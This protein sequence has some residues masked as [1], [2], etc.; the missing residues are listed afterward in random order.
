M[1]P[2]V[3]LAA[4]ES[5]RMGRPKALLPTGAGSETFVERIV[6]T[7][8]SAGVDR[9]V[10]V[11]GQH[12]KEITAVLK[13]LSPLVRTVRNPRVEG[14]QLSSLL[15]GLEA[16]DR[17]DAGGMLVTLVDVPLVAG[18]TIARLLDA[19]GSGAAPIVRP[20]HAGRH[21][22]PVIFARTIFD[23]LR[24]ADPRRGAKEVVRRHAKEILEVDVDDEGAFLDVDTPEEYRRV[25]DR[26]AGG[27]LK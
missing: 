17:P 15:I 3:V 6:R 22:H 16:I 14:G 5:R 7:L 24:A 18:S 1:V 4:G 25:F 23:E 27:G 26:D 8:G 2:G 20:V 12:T 10:V 9:I 13:G 19:F 21:G 11:T